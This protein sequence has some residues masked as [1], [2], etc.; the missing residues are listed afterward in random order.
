ML[1]LLCL[2]VFWASHVTLLAEPPEKPKTCRTFQ[3]NTKTERNWWIVCFTFFLFP[4]DVWAYPPPTTSWS[5]VILNYKDL[6]KVISRKVGEKV[7]N[8]A[9]SIEVAR[10]HFSIWWEHLDDIWFW[11]GEESNPI[12]GFKSFSGISLEV[13]CLRV[14]DSNTQAVGSNPGWGKKIPH[15]ARCSQKMKVT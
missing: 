4:R 5:S 2:C 13:Q 15:A 10:A 8:R 11:K 7:R 1:R 14:Q 9:Q 6:H 3:G 12:L